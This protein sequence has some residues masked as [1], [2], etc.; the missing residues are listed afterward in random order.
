MTTIFS[1]TISMK[2]GIVGVMITKQRRSNHAM[3]K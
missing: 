1:F 2:L 3:P